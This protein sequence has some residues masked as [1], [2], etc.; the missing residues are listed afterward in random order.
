MGWIYD[1]ER[2]EQNL[3]RHGVGLRLAALVFDDA[4][5]ATR[6]DPTASDNSRSLTLGRPVASSPVLLLV[7]HATAPDHDGRG[8]I[9]G[10]RRATPAERE[11][12]E[13]AQY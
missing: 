1:L 13:S 3:T 12:Y 7:L 8:R 6:P 4:R 11:A 10:A 9:L 2:G 5:A